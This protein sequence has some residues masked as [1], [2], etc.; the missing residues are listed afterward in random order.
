MQ[1]MM[2]AQPSTTQMSTGEARV[3][4]PQSPNISARLGEDII[5]LLDV[6]G[7][8]GFEWIPTFDSSRLVFVC[9]ENPD[10]W[11]SGYTRYRRQFRFRAQR[12]GVH[13]LSW[14]YK[15]RWESIARAD[16]TMCIHVRS[17]R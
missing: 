7:Q 10:P 12:L 14:V 11:S 5:V 16:L 6:D 15:R 13:E 1:R 3:L 2:N 4:T 9:R 17:C 8:P